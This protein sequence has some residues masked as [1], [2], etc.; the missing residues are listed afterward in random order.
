MS[1][2]VAAL[3]TIIIAD[4]LSPVLLLNEKLRC[5]LQSAM[6]AR[7]VDQ[8]NFELLYRSQ[9]ASVEELQQSLARLRG[10]PPSSSCDTIGAVEV[11]AEDAEATR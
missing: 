5:E 9:A 8:A 4:E 7:R 10:G 3:L 11:L 2:I 6:D 1:E